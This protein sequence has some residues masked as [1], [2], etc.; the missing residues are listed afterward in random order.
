MIHHETA[1]RAGHHTSN[2]CPYVPS[3]ADVAAREASLTAALR[4][5]IQDLTAVTGIVYLL[6]PGSGLRAAMIGGSPPVMFTMP[7]QMALDAPYASAQAWR[8]GTMVMIGEPAL[9]SDDAGLARLVPFP[10]SV[11]A[12]PL[13]ADGHCFG[14][15]TVIRLPSQDGMMGKGQHRRLREIGDRLAVEM[16]QLAGRGVPLTPGTKPLL[17]PVFTAHPAPSR[18][19][20]TWGL[21]EVPGSTGLTMSYQVYKLGVALNEAASVRDVTA[22]TEAQMMAPCGAGALVLSVLRDGRLWVEGHCGMP[23]E[24]VKQLHGSSAAGGTPASDT[25]HSRDPMLFHNRAALLAAYPDAAEDGQQAWAFLPLAASGRVV[26]VC[27]LGF[28]EEHLFEAEEQATLMIMASM[29]G[30]IL[31]RAL[32]AESEHALAESLQM[33]L[34]PRILSDLP[35]VTTTARY[36]P[37]LATAGPGGDWY[38]V[39]TLPAGRIGLVVGDVEGHSIESSVI[40]GQLRSALLAYA[41]EGHG[42]AAVLTRTSQLLTELDTELMATCCF[43]CL[44]VAAGVAEVALAGHPAPLVRRPGGR[45]DALEGSPG[46]PLGVQSAAEYQAFEATLEPGSL[47]LL[48][49]DGLAP[50]QTADMTDDVRRLLTACGHNDTHNLEDLGDRLIATVPD[51]PERRD[52]VVLLLGFYEGAG[53]DPSHRINRMEIQRHDLSGVKAARAFVRDSLRAWG[54]ERAIDDIEIMASEVVTNALIHAD[55]HVDLR[56]R[57]YPDHIRLEVRDSAP[58]PPVPSS[59]S[60]SEEENAKAEHGR[61]LIIVDGL[62]SSW[63][64]SPSGRGKTVWLELSV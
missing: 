55:S 10:Y 49:T 58:M 40:M 11:V 3:A 17:L 23:S 43:V 32:L 1:N 26:G 27:S 4:E 52:D 48:Y 7:E 56:L 6:E 13:T 18:A 45:I 46:V 9:N 29:L 38:D 24:A 54:L 20:A 53:L 16:A 33:S 5:A 57:E 51:S 60:A 62:A 14:T 21:P 35:E 39:I 61:G 64:S 15:L 59:L 19:A 34:L 37:A 42:P 63:G 12:T 31:T 44:D 41:H 30:R 36:L 8:S 22:A 28:A 50:L 25:L 47:L 2:R